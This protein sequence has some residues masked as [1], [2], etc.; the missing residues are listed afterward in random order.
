MRIQPARAASTLMIIGTAL[1]TALI[2]A[3]AQARGAAGHPASLHLA[4]PNLSQA[5][6]ARFAALRGEGLISGVVDGAGGRPLTGVCVVATGPGGSVLAVTHSDGRYSLGGLRP[7]GYALHYSACGAG[8]H[9]VD[10]WSGGASW[11]GGATTVTVSRGQARELAPVTLSTA[12]AAIPAAL[13]PSLAGFASGTGLPGGLR[14][15]AVAAMAARATSAASRGAIAGT[16]T[17]RGRPLQGICVIA[18]GAGYGQTR[19]TKTGH[20]RIAKLGPGRYFVFFFTGY[21]GRNSG[22]WLP[23][24]YKGVNGPIFRHPARVRVTA[25]HTTRGIDAALQLGGQISGTVRSLH[26]KRLPRV[27][28]F[29]QGKDGRFFVAG[30]GESGRRGNYAVHSLF[31]GKYQVAFVPKFCGNNGNYAPQ[32]WPDAATQRHARTIVIKRGLIVS[33]VDAAL[34]PGAIISGVVRAGSARGALLA[35]I[36]VEVEP[37]SPQIFP[38]FD[39]TRTGKDGRYRVTGLTTGRY[40]LSFSRGCG[41]NGNYLPVQRS[42]SVIVSQIRSGVDA[43]LPAGAIIKGT[44]TNTKGTP[45]RGICVEASGRGFGSA[46]TNAEGKYSIIALPTGRYTVNYSGGCGNRGSY[47]PQFYRGQ[48]NAG[49]ATPVS[50]TAGQTTPGI[51]AVMQPGGT[52]TGVVTDPAG[53]KLN[54]VCVLIDSLSVTRYGYPFDIVETTKGVFAARNLVPGLYAVDFNCFFFGQ[55]KFAN[56]WFKGQPGQ[57]AANDVSAPAGV[58]ASGVNAVLRRGGTITGVVTNSAGKPISGMCVQ[59]TPHGSPIATPS[60]FN[61]PALGFT[62]SRGVYQVGPIPAATYDV[63]IGCFESG[64]YGSRW[65]GGGASRAS[66]KPVTVTN[67]GTTTGVSAVLTVGGSISGEV[68]TG[69][70]QP[71]LNVC[72]QAEDAANNTFGFAYTNRQGR[73]SMGGLSSGS[74]EVTFIDCGFG[75]HHVLLG[76]ATRLATVIAPHTATGVNEKLLPA[77][78][79]SG[80]VRGGPGATPQANACV[81]AVSVGSTSASTYNNTTTGSHGGYQLFGLAPG[82]YNVYFGDPFCAFAGTGYAPQ[83]YNNQASQATAAK[84]IVTSGGDTRKIDATVGADGAISGTVTSNPHA[85]VSGECVKATPVHPV[86]EP[87]FGAVLHPVIGVTAAHGTYALIGLLPGKYT[88][89]FFAGCGDD[90]GFQTQWWHHSGTASGATVITVPANATVT[91]IDA[92]LR[93][94]GG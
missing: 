87:L 30:N 46:T 9:Y 18:Y 84:V 81:V 77:G 79:I 75:R 93:H 56:Q 39:F 89:E 88:V 27:C 92:G 22:N 26:G 47:A 73:Y 85:P 57:G 35:G 31:P 43:F 19:T 33:H 54:R 25:G 4:S 48:A 8:G 59:V 1:A 53:H 50:A 74:Y 44:V 6:A 62:N 86:P 11:P 78:S 45:V 34:P 3:P 91:G 67:G 29:A 58:P 41:N 15:A 64:R 94:N 10:Q 69:A 38:V 28:V 37:R 12:T 83:W 24:Y 40:R 16:V 60:F 82:A 7:G 5:A 63:Q 55:H 66:A 65:V 71:Q 76:T 80:I 42:V 36:C 49:S 20:Y 72:V 13:P 70:N 51:D 68:T 90:T 23:Q 61:Q 21:C 2:S 17:G 52:I 32:W 14:P